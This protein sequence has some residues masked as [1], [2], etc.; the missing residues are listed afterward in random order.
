MKK[1]FIIPI[2]ALLS[3]CETTN[4]TPADAE[5]AAHAA[6]AWLD[7]AREAKTIIL[8]EK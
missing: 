5:A 1:L 2:L 6:R 4:M 8:D 7:V 3:S